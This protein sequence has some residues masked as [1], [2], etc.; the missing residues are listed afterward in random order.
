M[1]RTNAFESLVIS[2]FVRG[3]SVRDVEASLAD[4]LGA[5]G[6]LSKSNV[7]RVY[8]AIKDE[9][10]TW[11]ARNLS[12]VSLEYLFLDGTPFRM[13]EG[14]RAGPVLA[15]WGITTEGRPVLVGLDAGASE[16]TDAWK[17]FSDSL[18]AR[19]LGAPL[20]LVSDG[21]PGL[22]G[23]VELVLPNSLGQRC[24]IHRC[25]NV[26]A[27]VPVEHQAEVKGAFWAI[28]DPTGE[29]P[30][31]R[32][33]AVARQRA[34]DFSVRFG[35]RFPSAVA[36]LNDDLASLFAYLRFP[37]NTTSGSGTQASSNA[38]SARPAGGSK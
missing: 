21:A 20:L 4:A 15:G 36:C 33:I 32:S 13:H 27:K 3:L 12:R 35:R 30:G 18:I 28:F 16:S 11:K 5:E 17:G 10:D 23:A 38:P 25:R 37:V 8:E 9:F 6:A 7:T 19:G 22:I 14:A 34:A 2:G 29:P 31:D 26:L 1:C 24:A